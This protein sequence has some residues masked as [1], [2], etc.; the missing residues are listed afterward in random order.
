MFDGIAYGKA[1]AVIGM[2]ENYLGKEVFRQGVHNYL[3]AHLYANATAE[4]FWS[5]QAANSHLP[6]DKIMSSF[7]TQPGVPLLTFSER[8]AG[9]VPVMQSRFFLSAEET[10]RPVGGRAQEWTVPVCLKTTGHPICRVLTPVDSALP[11]PVDAGLPFFYGNAGAKGYYRTA[12][13]PAQLGAIVAKAESSMTPPERVGLLGDRWALVQSGQASVG[14]FLN[15][16]LALKEDPSAAVLDTTHQAI[17]KID[18]DIAS[19][20][21]RAELAAVLQRQFGPVYS[22]LGSPVKK[23]PFD[24]QQLRGTLFELLGEAHDAAVLTEAQLLTARVFAVNNERDKTLDPTL[25]DAAVQVS[26]ANGD[27]GLYDKVLAVSRNFS[28]PGQQTDALRLLARFRD[29]ALVTR[30]LDLIASGEVRNQDSWTMLTALLRDRAT[31]DQAWGYMQQN[32]EKVS[33]QFTVSS[34]AEVVGATGAF[35]TVKRRDEVISF[36]AV[37]KV[38]AAERTLAKAV[39]SI[40]DC[41]R[42]QSIQE[43]KLHAWLQLQAK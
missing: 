5:A 8:Q 40:N 22:A 28:D 34:G 16:V 1:G 27:A 29:P 38:A 21:D 2:V 39:D 23:E 17:E 41:I 14:D 3:Q 25:A 10:N 43:S 42:L 26:A 36:F 19:D 37:H 35:C 6:V 18:S 32:W 20:A 9:S 13:T 12:Y 4:D 30:T 33:A 15:L 31:R 7:V 11:L 24:R